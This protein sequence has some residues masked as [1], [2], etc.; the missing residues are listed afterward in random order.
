MTQA[1]LRDTKSLK[2]M[3]LIDLIAWLCTREGWALAA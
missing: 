2:N 3:E 1:F